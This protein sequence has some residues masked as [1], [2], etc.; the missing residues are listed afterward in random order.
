MTSTSSTS[1]GSQT[2][3]PKESWVTYVKKI[4]QM[5]GLAKATLLRDFRRAGGIQDRI[6]LHL[7]RMRTL[8]I[9]VNMEPTR[10]KDDAEA[11]RYR[12][13]GDNLMN[14]QEIDIPAALKNYC[15][16]IMFAT[17]G[18]QDLGLSYEKRSLIS[19]M[20]GRYTDCLRDI[21]SAED[22]DY[23]R[24]LLPKLY[25][26]K[27]KCLVA[28]NSSP[29]DV[30]IALNVVKNR[31]SYMDAED[32]GDDLR[33]LANSTVDELVADAPSPDAESVAAEPEKIEP[34]VKGPPCCIPGATGINI[35]YSN[36]RDRH[37]VALRKFQPGDI[38]AAVPIYASVRKSMKFYKMCDECSKETLIGIPCIFCANVVYCSD[39][40]Q[41]KA[42]AQYH[43]AECTILGILLD[44][45]LDLYALLGMRILL[46]A[47]HEAGNI[48][49]LRTML[50]DITAVTD[51]EIQG[52]TEL[53]FDT[54]KYAT[55]HSL[56]KDREQYMSFDK[57]GT[58]LSALITIY[59]LATMTDA[60]GSRY[61]GNLIIMSKDPDLRFLVD[62]LVKIYG[63]VDQTVVQPLDP[64]PLEEDGMVMAPFLSLFN[65]SCAPNAVVFGYTQNVMIAL[66]QINVGDEICIA[67]QNL[68]F[69]RMPRR[70]RRRLL[71]QHYYLQCPC[72][73]CEEDWKPYPGLTRISEIQKLTLELGNSLRLAQNFFSNIRGGQTNG[74]TS[75]RGTVI[76]NIAKLSQRSQPTKDLIDYQE[77]LENMCLER[78]EFY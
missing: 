74:D 18:T 70:K 53:R 56:L 3:E 58:S 12:N 30:A 1:S 11:R 67:Y 24:K 59:H 34:I 25:A 4:N 38:I 69:N 21:R 45:D 28:L 29:M 17:P 62:L 60:F 8:G 73:A 27:I 77:M 19:F 75:A 46:K 39:M 76:H 32:I 49:N 72:K 78:Y 20:E 55:V 52:F 13:I 7:S 48:R 42:W 66:N 33:E 5:Q 44:A 63:I 31:L 64:T 51:P 14:A 47:L 40:C 10:V 6:E 15:L 22:H 71:F 35:S 43:A 61:L 50:R 37:V 36:E 54:S 57:A 65:H 2:D 68:R 9:E 23:P 26:R 16:S 41:Y